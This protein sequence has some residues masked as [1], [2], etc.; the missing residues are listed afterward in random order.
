MIAPECQFRRKMRWK[1]SL[2]IFLFIVWF[3]FEQIVNKTT[4]RNTMY[5]GEIGAPE[6][7][8]SSMQKKTRS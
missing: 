4:S 7:T 2:E 5:M 3:D 8:P 6:A 1:G